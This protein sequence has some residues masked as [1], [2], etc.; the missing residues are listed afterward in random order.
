MD[1]EAKKGIIIK[2]IQFLIYGI[3]I[4]GAFIDRGTSPNW[5]FY[6]LLIGILLAN[7]IPLKYRTN[8]YST[9]PGIILKNHTRRFEN[10]IEMM[11]TCIVIFLVILL[12]MT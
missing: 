7:F 8:F 9:N 11:V 10:I 2:V 3:S 1:K 12:N 5:P 4:V 6:L